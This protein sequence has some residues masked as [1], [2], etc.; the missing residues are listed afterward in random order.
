VLLSAFQQAEQFNRPTQARYAQLAARCPL[1]AVL[2]EGLAEEPAA[3]VRGAT[4]RHDDALRGE[5]TVAVVGA[6]Y[7]GAL[8][9]RDLG[10][11]GADLRRRFA[12]DVTHDPTR[13]LGAA[14][15]M[16]ER[17]AIA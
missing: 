16:L 12:F 5:W 9:A 7:A 1:V 6:H 10:D 13:V 2:G 3:G 17:V 11:S 14:Q 4:L 8:I 15:S